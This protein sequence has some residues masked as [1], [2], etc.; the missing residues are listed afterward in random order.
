MNHT[1]SHAVQAET[2]QPAPAPSM[3]Q[4]PTN[5]DVEFTMTPAH[6]DVILKAMAEAAAARTI[7]DRAMDAGT[8]A[9]G[10][11]AGVGIAAGC[12]AIGSLIIGAFSS[13]TV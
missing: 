9:A 8:V 5:I 7:A 6:L 2:V 12:Y 13:P 4:G 3:P 10:V 1:Q 11:A